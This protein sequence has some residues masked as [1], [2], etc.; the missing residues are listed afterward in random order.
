M[1]YVCVWLAGGKSERLSHKHSHA[2]KLLVTRRVLHWRLGLCVAMMGMGNY[3][4]RGSGDGSIG[5]CISAS[6]SARIRQ[7]AD[8]EHKEHGQKT[9]RQTNLVTLVEN[10]VCLCMRVCCESFWMCGRVEMGN[11][12]SAWILYFMYK[13]L[14]Y[15]YF[16]MLV[17]LKYFWTHM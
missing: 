15:Y 10:F 11:E 8:E 9:R 2:G 1:W 17:L 13:F 5:I 16:A 12:R 4:R 3:T 7:H 6:T 14:V